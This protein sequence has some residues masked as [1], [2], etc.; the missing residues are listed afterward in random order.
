MNRDVSA[1][2]VMLI[3]AH[4]WYSGMGSI[5]ERAFSQIGCVTKVRS[6]S[7]QIA[8]SSWKSRITGAISNR[9]KLGN[10][11]LYWNFKN[12]L[13]NEIRNWK[14]DLLITTC[15][16]SLPPQL[17]EECKSICDSLF[18]QLLVD[19]PMYLYRQHFV[20]YL[21]ENV[22]RFD[23]NFTFVR[24]AVPGLYQI[25]AQRAEHLHFAHDPRIHKPTKLSEED[26]EIYQGNVAYIGNWGPFKETWAA[27]LAPCG[28]KVW[29]KNWDH[30]DWNSP[31][32]KCWQKPGREELGLGEDMAKVCAATKVIFNL[33][34]VE[35]E[36][37]HSLKTFEIPACGGFM[38][39]NRT[40][41]QLE[42][43]EEDRHA[44]YYSTKE[45]LLDKLDFYLK[46][47]EARKKIAH[48]GRERVLGETYEARSRKI[49]GVYTDMMG[50]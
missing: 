27:H 17:I 2:R 40:D 32:K 15:G 4:S 22:P 34:M 28:L 12:R 20:S 19:H 16:S 1:P 48:A 26:H 31:A 6:L 41:E 50:A 33:I 18:F 38:L 13:L 5:F 24:S 39:T 11:F 30:G 37:A 10:R 25:G 35:N 8:W 9:S 45:E 36:C 49:L 46:H 47:D 29:G 14:P 21:L 23:C 42:I 7:S 3:A 44:A 43:L